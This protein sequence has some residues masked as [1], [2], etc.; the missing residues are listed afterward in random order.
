MTWILQS[1]QQRARTGD[2]NIQFQQAPAALRVCLLESLGGEKEELPGVTPAPLKM[3]SFL[4][5]PLSL[6]HLNRLRVDSE[7]TRI[8]GWYLGTALFR[9]WEC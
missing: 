1:S 2:A 8:G 5:P 9:T 6:P 3:P 4:L 7:M